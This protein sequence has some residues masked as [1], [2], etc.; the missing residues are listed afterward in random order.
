MP[1]L[2]WIGK[3]AVRKHHKEVP[4]RLLEEHE[5]KHVGDDD[6]DNLLVQGDNLHALKALLPYYAGEV[7]CVY[8]DPPYNTGNEDWAYNDNVNSPEIN[9]WLGKTVGKEAEDLSRHDKWLCMMIPRLM[10][11]HKLLAENGSFWMSIDDN[12]VHHARAL[13][14]EVF[15]RQNFVDTVIWQKNFAPKNSAKFFS[16]DHDYILV[17]AK[18]KENWDRN[19][20]PRSDEQDE[21]YSNPDDDP[22]GP[23]ASDNL[24]ARNPYSK[25]LYSVE[26]PSGSVIDGPPKGTYW[27]I[28]KEKLK[29]LDEDNRIWWGEDGDNVPRLKRFLSEVKDGVVPQTLWTYEEVGHT[30]ESKKE[31]VQICDFE[32]SD[33]VFVT[34]KPTRL[35]ERILDIATDPGDLV[36]DSFAG[37][38]TTGHATLKKNDFD[39][40][41]RRFILVEMNEEVAQDIAHQRLKRAV[42]GYPYEGT[43]KET[44]MEEKLTVRSFKKGNKIYAESQKVKE[45]HADQYDKI[46][47]EVDDG[48]FRLYGQNDIQEWKEGLGSGF[49]YCTLGSP[50]VNSDGIIRGE[51]EYEELARHVFYTETGDTLPQDHEMNPP[52]VSAQQGMALYLLSGE[53]SSVLT[54]SLLNDI[55]TNGEIENTVVY[56]EACRVGESMLKERGVTFRQLPYEVRVS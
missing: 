17:Y 8:I 37:T 14:D 49:R 25:G 45:N 26:K 15:G 19:L 43:E 12:E 47:R 7:D 30:Q 24:L 23:W 2:D 16:S 10:L 34:P 40:G 11:L 20:L 21:R 56:G 27:R 50:L 53:E 55:P 41:S 1:T 39:G 46:R 4:F 44:L 5:E 36:L 3:S 54:R 29:E 35:V 31:L 13:L 9:E 51:V 48:M 38:A 32:S 42:E 6:T 52:L 22:R 18:D 28:S 33:D